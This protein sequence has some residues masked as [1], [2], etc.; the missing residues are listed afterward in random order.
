MHDN[1]NIYY[2]ARNYD[3]AKILQNDY[4]NIDFTNN[5]EHALTNVWINYGSINSPLHYDMFDNILTQI[6]GTKEIYLFAPSDDRYLY[7]DIFQ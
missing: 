5:L 1:K 4:K 6:D 2:L 7:E 3:I